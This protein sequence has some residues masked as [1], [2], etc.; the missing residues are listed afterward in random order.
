MPRYP[1]TPR[2]LRRA[3]LDHRCRLYTPQANKWPWSDTLVRITPQPL[4]PG[5]NSP[6]TASAAPAVNGGRAKARVARRIWAAP[7]ASTWRY[8]MQTTR[9]H[10]ETPLPDKMRP[11]SDLYYPAGRHNFAGWLA[12]RDKMRPRFDRPDSKQS[13]AFL[14]SAWSSPRLMTTS[15]KSRPNRPDSV[16]A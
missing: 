6:H 10:G 1:R 8:W 3:S 2:A 11:A 12:G 16:S 4:A 15:N 7:I 5:Q 13:P 9:S 14:C